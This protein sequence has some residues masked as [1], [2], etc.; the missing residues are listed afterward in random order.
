MDAG[1]H[2]LDADLVAIA[3]CVPSDGTRSVGTKLGDKTGI[4]M[5]IRGGLVMFG[6]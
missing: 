1:G 5:T 6:D 3:S 4:W 2:V